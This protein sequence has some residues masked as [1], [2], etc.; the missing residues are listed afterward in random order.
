M[1]EG[2]FHASGGN[3]P[4]TGTIQRGIHKSLPRAASLH[5]DVLMLFSKLDVS[6][7]HLQD[8]LIS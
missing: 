2:T 7:Y 1:K 3:S 8:I 5:L 6:A 4:S